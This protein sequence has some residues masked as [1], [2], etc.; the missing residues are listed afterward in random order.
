MTKPKIKW[1]VQPKPSRPLRERDW[2]V[3]E[4]P[5]GRPVAYITC[6]EPYTSRAAVTGEHPELTVTVTGIVIRQLWE[7]ASCLSEAKAMV[8]R[9]FEVNP[10]LLP[11]D[12]PR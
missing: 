3:A 7:K 4:L 10:D 6:A 1:K 5:N 9:F 2:P 8:A 11:E 12:Y